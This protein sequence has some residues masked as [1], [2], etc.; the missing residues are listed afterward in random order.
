MRL[1][2]RPSEGVLQPIHARAL[3]IQDDD[4][5]TTLFL[6]RRPGGGE[7]AADRAGEGAITAALW[8]AGAGGGAGEL[9]HAWCTHSDGHPGPG[10]RVRHLA[11]GDAGEPGVDPGVEQKLVAVAGQAIGSLRP[12]RVELGAG[13]SLVRGQP[14]RADGQRSQDRG[15]PGRADRSTACRCCE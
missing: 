15:E 4:G 6:D 13:H 11:S 14:A 5:T 10:Q 3:A 7:A 8:R 1:A 12:A 9:A 2:R